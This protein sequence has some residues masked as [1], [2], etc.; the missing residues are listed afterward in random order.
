[1]TGLVLHMSCRTNCCYEFRCI[2][3]MSCPMNSK[4]EEGNNNYL[5]YTKCI[6]FYQQRKI[7]LY[8]KCLNKYVCDYTATPMLNWVSSRI[9]GTG[10]NTIY[11]DGMMGREWETISCSQLYNWNQ[12]LGIPQK[13]IPSEGK[14]RPSTYRVEFVIRTAPNRTK[15]SANINMEIQ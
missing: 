3:T 12:F 14:I 13:I 15:D 6:C 4:K 11:T 1:M 8:L 7:I 5:I 9:R 10:S 2:T